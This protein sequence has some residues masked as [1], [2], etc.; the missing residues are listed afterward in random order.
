MKSVAVLIPALNEAATIAA[1]VAE[2]R[3]HLSGIEGVNFTLVV[4]NDG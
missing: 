3:S 2:I 1:N 4:I